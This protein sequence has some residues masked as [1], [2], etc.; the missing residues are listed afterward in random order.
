MHLL[1]YGVQDGYTDGVSQ[2]LIHLSNGRVEA[3][4]KPLTVPCFE[5]GL[6]EYPSCEH[7]SAFWARTKAIFTQYVRK[8]GFEFDPLAVYW[9]THSC[10][11]PLLYGHFKL[12]FCPFFLEPLLDHL[13]PTANF[14]FYLS[15]NQSPKVVKSTAF[16]NQYPVFYLPLVSFF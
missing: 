9:N 2:I 4:P 1:S 5:E 15:T 16:C 14:D 10:K 13:V 12:H 11:R 7:F 3:S 8:T 6:G